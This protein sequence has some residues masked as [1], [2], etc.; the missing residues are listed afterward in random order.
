QTLLTSDGV[1][2][3]VLNLVKVRTGFR[4]SVPPLGSRYLSLRLRDGQINLESSV[5]R[6]RRNTDLPVVIPYDPANGIQPQTHP[7]ADSLGSEKG[8]KNM[9]L[10]LRRD[11]G[12]IVANLHQHAVEVTRGPH[13]QLTLPLHGLDGVGNQVRPNLIE[14]TAI[15]ANSRQ[16]F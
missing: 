5:T 7:L 2:G 9:R 3:W 4:H 10:N 8:F 14:L 12:S 11:S 6:L 13:P 1:G 16:V 15:G